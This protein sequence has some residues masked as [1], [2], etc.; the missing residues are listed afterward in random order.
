MHWLQISLW[1][2]FILLLL[3][4]IAYPITKIIFNKFSLDFGYP[5]AKTISLLFVSYLIFVTSTLHILTFN[6]LSLI[7]VIMLLF[8]IGLI[9]IKNTYKLQP[10][11]LI[12]IFFEELLFLICF[13]FWTIIRSQEPSIHSLEKFMDFGFINSILRTNYF[14]PLDIWYSGHPIN[15]YYFGHLTGAMLIKLTGVLPAI[16][17]NLIL[18]TIFALGMTQVF[19][20]VINIIDFFQKKVYRIVQSIKLVFFGLLGA[21]LVNLAGN[22]HTIYLFTKGYPNESPVPFW[23]IFSWFDPTKYWYPNATRFIPFTIH[24]FPSYSYVVADLHG[25]VFDIPFVLLT[26][27][28]LFII[29]INNSNQ[30]KLLNKNPNFKFQISNQF[31][32]FKFSNLKNSFSSLKTS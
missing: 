22:L 17:Y 19:S 29:F 16:G 15:Y 32:K 8:L 25:H 7:F 30:N 31:S 9:F 24:E 1:W 27:A 2:Y 18:S 14:P 10:K 4:L 11:Q 5:F 6:R 13:L 28:F 3:G 21:L 20:L 23:T 12:L 26:I